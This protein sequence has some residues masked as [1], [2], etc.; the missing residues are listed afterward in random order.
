MYRT[1]LSDN[2]KLKKAL[3]ILFALLILKEIIVAI[4]IGQNPSPVGDKY[5]ERNAIN[6]AAYFLKHGV[7]SNS[8]LPHFSGVE[9]VPLPE[10]LKGSAVYT[11]YPPGPEYLIW[12]SQNV[13]GSR[14]IMCQRFLPL[15]VNTALSLIFLITVLTLF[16]TKKSIILAFLLIAPPMFSYYMHGLH[17]QG[18]AL[19]ILLLQIALLWKYLFHNLGFKDLNLL[20]FFLSFLQ[21]WLSFDYAF[22]ATFCATPFLILERR[23]FKE[24]L[25]ISFWSG[26]GFTAAHLIHFY[27]VI[28]Y[29]GSFEAAVADLLN[30]AKE[31]ALNTSNVIKPGIDKLTPLSNL[32]DYLW[33]VSGRGKYLGVNLIN[34][35]WLI[36]LLHFVQKIQLKWKNLNFS[37]NIGRRDLVALLTSI[38]VSG[39]WTMIMKQH[40]F[41]H[42][43]IARHYYLVYLI[44]CYIL[45][46]GFQIQKEEA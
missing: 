39:A 46:K 34:I 31:R 30:A 44:A 6:G 8:G 5:S 3:F 25:L 36:I 38:L 17:Y 19:S 4:S 32:K 45:I 37:V 15:T 24:W 1:I 41:I 2:Q 10:D 22:L 13:C 11:H 7:T 28:T 40:A 35:I 43:F 33:R 12:L 23:P 18:Y 42:G 21:G 29:L 14:N 16:T 20:L 26:L 9:I 27:Q